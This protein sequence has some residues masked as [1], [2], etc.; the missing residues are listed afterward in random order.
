MRG[1]DLLAVY[2]SG[3]DLVV[4]LEPLI[5][6]PNVATALGSIPASSDTL[7]SARG[8]AYEAVLKIKLYEKSRKFPLFEYGSLGYWGAISLEFVIFNE[9]KQKKTCYEKKKLKNA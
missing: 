5:A 3:S 2:V 8:A 7:E 9:H 4:W 1:W 6:Y